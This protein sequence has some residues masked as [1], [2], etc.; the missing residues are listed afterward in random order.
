MPERT[1]ARYVSGINPLNRITPAACPKLRAR[2]SG[3]IHWDI[4]CKFSRS[5]SDR[6]MFGEN[7][8]AEDRER[9]RTVEIFPRGISLAMIPREHMPIWRKREISDENF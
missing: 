7:I 1:N 6:E 5:P 4:I 8:E 2:S 9:E 3:R